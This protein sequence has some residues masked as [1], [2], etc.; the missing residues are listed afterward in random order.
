MVLCLSPKNSVNARK[1]FDPPFPS[2]RITL[3]CSGPCRRSPRKETARK[4]GTNR[5]FPGQNPYY[6]IAGRGELNRICLP[7]PGGTN[8]AFS[9][10]LSA[11]SS[12]M[13]N[14]FGPTGSPL[15]RASNFSRKIFAKSPFGRFSMS[16][17]SGRMV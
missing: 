3:F 6:T 10:N 4:P 16:D 17:R 14:S 2:T 11:I 5:D 8:Y 7:V 13:R 12:C 15:K 9:S 1:S